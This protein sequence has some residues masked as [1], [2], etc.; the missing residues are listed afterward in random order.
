MISYELA[1]QI[2][3]AILLASRTRIKKSTLAQFFSGFDLQELVKLA[4]QRYKNFGFFIY[5]DKDS[6]E[7]VT[8]PELASYLI[9]FFGLKE[10]E[11]LQDFLEV[12]AI[13]AYGGPLSL[14]EINRL[15]GKKSFFI[16]KAL[17]A[18]GF[19][20]K[21]KKFYRVSNKFLKILG[22]RHEK[23]LPDYQKL[24]KELKGEK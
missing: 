18:E 12:L 22:F 4:N 6:V 24:R 3:E 10:N 1:I 8:R 2:L 20:Q 14:A 19:I 16:L 21:E 17:V 13:V 9:N 7:L 15:R 23:D 5:E 11:S